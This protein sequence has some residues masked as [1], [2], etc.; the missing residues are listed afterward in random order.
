MG[1]KRFPETKRLIKLESMI[2][3]SAGNPRY[4]CFFDDD[5]SATTEVNGAVGWD[6]GNAKDYLDRRVHVFFNTSGTIYRIEV[7]KCEQCRMPDPDHKMDCT[8]SSLSK[9][10]EPSKTVLLEVTVRRTA[11]NESAF[12]TP[13]T[14]EVSWAAADLL[15]GKEKDGYT[16]HRVI[17]ADY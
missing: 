8:Q 15:L 6:L 12:W 4:R 1:Q 14:T 10:D 11:G 5:S 2:S 3:S 9:S 13:S 17:P 7:A 16:F